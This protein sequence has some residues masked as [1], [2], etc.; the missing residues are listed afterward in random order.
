MERQDVVGR[1][2]NS[3]LASR[4]ARRPAAG[5]LTGRF[6]PLVRGLLIVACVILL[7]GLSG[8]KLPEVTVAQAADETAPNKKPADAEKKDADKKDADKP[9]TD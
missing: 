4:L 1:G 2:A 9:T 7:A 6:Q 3:K 5:A 8:L